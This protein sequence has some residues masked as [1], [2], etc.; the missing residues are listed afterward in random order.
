MNIASF[1]VQKNKKKQKKNVQLIGLYRIVKEVL[2][3]LILTTI[4]IGSTW[5][6]KTSLTQ[7]YTHENHVLF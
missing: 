6:N 7:T 1:F 5:R 3:N 4:V 2:T